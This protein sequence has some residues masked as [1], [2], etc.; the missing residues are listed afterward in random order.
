M[1][2]TV[3]FVVTFMAEK[4]RYRQLTFFRCMAENEA[5]AFTQAK[6][7]HPECELKFA[8]PI[9][10]P[11]DCAELI[12]N[13]YRSVWGAKRDEAGSITKLMTY[14]A[15]LFSSYAQVLKFLTA[16]EFNSNREL[17]KAA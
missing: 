9:E 7:A 12:R 5:D 3:P 13:E 1:T 17:P 11:V 16:D 14:S 2:N 10:N 8:L 15:E 4:L 6:A